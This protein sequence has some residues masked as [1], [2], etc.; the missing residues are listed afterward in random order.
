MSD[1]PKRR[2]SEALRAFNDQ[3][4]TLKGGELAAVRKAYAA[5]LAE[6]RVASDDPAAPVVYRGERF[7]LAKVLAA[8][9]PSLAA[10][11]GA[12]RTRTEEEIEYRGANWRS[13]ALVGAFTEYLTALSA[14]PADDDDEEAADKHE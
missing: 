13:V 10:A 1:A 12:F 6:A 11:G 2:Y 7:E 14:G 3:L 4:K 5:A 8:L 9:P